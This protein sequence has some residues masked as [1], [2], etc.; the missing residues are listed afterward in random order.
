MQSY[1]FVG[2][3]EITAAIVEGL[4]TDVADPPDVFLSPR[5]HDVA[6]AL[7][8]RFPNVRVCGTNQEV[9]DSTTTIVV[10]VR[11]QVAQDVLTGLVFRPAHV[12]VS[13]LA[14][15]SLEQLREWTAPAA[16]QVRSIPLPTVSRRA[17]R[18]AV[19]PDDVVARALFESVGDVV[20][21]RDEAALATFSTATATFAAHLDQLATI[22]HW[23]TEHGVAPEEADAYVAHVF[24][25]LGRTLLTHPGTLE[26]L[27][28]KHMTPGGINE[29]FLADLRGDGLRDSV[30]NSLDAVLARVSGQ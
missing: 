15:V 16:R 9:L 4:G 5:N 18:T 8:A 27:A 22:A 21:P 30:R 23:M 29:Q 20:V 1:G 11:P 17:G 12:V 14:G 13:V 26:D 2:T 10:A 24:G 7:A 28:G 25:E 6:H 3:G 19:Y